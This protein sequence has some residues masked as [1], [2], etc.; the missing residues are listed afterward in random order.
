MRWFWLIVFTGIEIVLFDLHVWRVFI[1]VAI[2]GFAV[3][4]HYQK[5]GRRLK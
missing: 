1:F 3:D 5:K 4:I 2:I